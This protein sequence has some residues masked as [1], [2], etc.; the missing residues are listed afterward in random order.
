MNSKRFIL[1]AVLAALVYGANFWGTSIYILDEAKN[2]GCAMEMYQRGDLIVPTFNGE[3]RT[4]KPAFHYFMMMSAYTLFDVS[5]F[6]ARLFS[7]LAGILTVLVVYLFTKKFL[8]EQV[9]FYTALAMIASLQL[10]IQFHL[11]VPDPYLLLLM[12]TS[13][14]L[15]FHGY[16]SNNSKI[17]YAFYALSALAFLTKGLIALALP[18]LFIFLFLLL[19]RELTWKKLMTL[20]LIPGILIFIIVALP[21]YAAVGYATHG[22]WLEGFFLKH[23]LSRFTATMEGHRG[24]FLAPFV[25]LIA[26]MLPFST[27]IIQAVAS[28]WARRKENPFVLFCLIL[29]IVIPGFFCFSKTILPS[30][31]APALPFLAI[32]LGAYLSRVMPEERQ[33][34]RSFVNHISLSVYTLI[35]CA[36]PIALYIGLNQEQSLADLR[37]I[38]FGFIVLPLAAVVAHYFYSVRKGKLSIYV[39]SG[40]WMIVTLFF[41]WYCYPLVD[42]RNPV[43]KSEAVIHWQGKP[44]AYFESLNPAFVFAN[45]QIILRLESKEEVVRFFQQHPDGYITTYASKLEQLIPDESY[46][47]VFRAKDL[48]ENGE[49]VILARKN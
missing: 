29:S 19:K 46:E 35:A 6:S 42:E 49:T 10:A 33:P 31:P 34:T 15:F 17:L 18:G 23:H 7:V 22:A 47:V 3:L 11:A 37:E 36:I 28:A 2:A 5:P 38:A 40:S 32:V 30:Y 39:L 48:F 24:F 45:K 26:A 44:I 9:A 13:L 4:D 20:K 16:Q 8:N 25:I 27:F 14:L 41:F 1:L 21:W 12:T 43:S